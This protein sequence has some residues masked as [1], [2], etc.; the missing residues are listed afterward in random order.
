MTK[1]ACLFPG[2]GSQSVGMGKD[3]FENFEDAR[4]LFGE[5]DQYADRSLS[6]LCFEGPQDALKRTI[7]TQPTILAASVVAW[8]CY[9]QAGGPKPAYVAGHSLGELSAMYA[10]GV[11]SLPAVVFLVEKR[12]QLMEACPAGA[13]SAVLGLK[14]EQL[15]ELCSQV[16]QEAGGG[17]EKVV[18]VANLNT[19]E[20]LVISGDPA[21]VAACGSKAKSAGGKVIPLPVGGAFHSPL[22]KEAAEEF[23][24]LISQSQ[25]SN[26]EFPVVQ[27]YNARS[28][29]EGSTLKEVLSMQMSNSVRWCQTV[30]YLLA[31]GVTDFVEIG[32]G[33]ALSGMV[34]KIDKGARVHNVED[35]SSLKQTMTSL[36]AAAVV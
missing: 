13:M 14:I 24:A 1:I 32:P 18:V 29:T 5:I 20:Q 35:S 2:Q 23:K 21:S 10:A 17:S 6:H 15:N 12:A 28:A 31:Q 11:L 7:N 19:R 33:K 30:E 26:A 25:F 3:L 22:M 27:N 34:K 16:V 9:R 36:Q 4:K 8:Q